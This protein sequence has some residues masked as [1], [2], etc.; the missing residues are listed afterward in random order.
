MLCIS[1]LLISLIGLV[2][3]G[4]ITYSVIISA[5]EGETVAVVVDQT[6]YPLLVSSASS[7]LYTGEAPEATQEYH[8]AKF[9][10]N[11]ATEAEAIMRHPVQ[12]DTPNEF[13]NRTSNG[14]ESAPRLPMLLAP[15]PNVDRIQSSPHLH[16]QIVTLHFEADPFQIELLHQNA[17]NNNTVKVICNMTRITLNGIQTFTDVQLKLGG[18]ST[19]YFPKL[20]YNIKLS[21]NQTLAGYRRFKLRALAS[22]PSYLREKIAYDVLQST[23]VP[24]SDFSFVRVFI[25]ERAYGLFGLVEIYRK[26]WLKN[27]FNGGRK[28]FD[29]GIFYKALYYSN[30][31]NLRSDLGYRGENQ[32]LYADGSYAIK[33]KPKKGEPGNYTRLM[34]F[35]R[36]L[37]NASSSSSSLDGQNVVREWEKQISTQ[38][39]VR[40]LAVEI[41]LGMSDGYVSN[42]NNYYLYDDRK[43]NQLV[44][45]PTDLDLTLGSTFTNLS[46]MWS[47]N[48]SQY[49]GMSLNRPLIQKLLEAEPLKEAFERV[50]IQLCNKTLAPT[51]INRYVDALAGFVRED[52]AWDKSLPR[53][54]SNG[55][56]ELAPQLLQIQPDALPPPYDYNTSADLLQRFIND[57]VTFEQALNGPTGHISLAGVRE[58]ITSQ[59][60]ALLSNLGYH[61]T[62]GKGDTCGRRHARKFTAERIQAGLQQWQNK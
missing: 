56:L 11:N 59:R 5:K 41:A 38:S 9:V 39:V 37:A 15:L 14:V 2:S 44:Y 40:N 17:T 53:A 32:S 22:D 30:G 27:E 6:P 55:W 1:I 62:K 50:L 34:E 61:R 8:Y 49:P 13:Y 19:R 54:T 57:N 42:S 26:S 12:A 23:G 58:W 35:T 45:I 33:T 43:Y 3:C 20:P 7:I 36:F 31:T 18:R 46:A 24:T 25:N 16:N 4:N 48:Y 60:E 28:K 21:K 51:I 29:V 10:G 47:G 52:V